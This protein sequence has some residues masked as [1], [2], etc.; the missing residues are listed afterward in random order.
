MY[1]IYIILLHTH[2]YMYTVSTDDMCIKLCKWWL[3]YFWQ[4]CKNNYTFLSSDIFRNILAQREDRKLIF[5]YAR[6]K[7]HK[8][9]HTAYEIW[10]TQTDEHDINDDLS[11]LATWVTGL[12]VY[13]R[14][15]ITRICVVNQNSILFIFWNAL[16]CHSQL[17]FALYRQ[18]SR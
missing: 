16:K 14:Q 3:R 2:T 18:R 6:Y 17:V 10:E 8:R 1:H 11:Q 9:W 4:F 15:R 13:T 5:L 12:T 7:W